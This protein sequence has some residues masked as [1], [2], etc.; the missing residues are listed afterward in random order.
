MQNAQ[1]AGQRRCKEKLKQ[2]K[3]HEEL[4]NKRKKKEKGVTIKCVTIGKRDRMSKK[5]RTK[6]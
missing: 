6:G 4:N 2:V 5:K 3:Q 1:G